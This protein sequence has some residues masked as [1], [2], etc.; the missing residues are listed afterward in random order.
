MSSFLG[1]VIDKNYD[2]IVFV[3]KY[4]NFDKTRVANSVDVIKIL[5]MFIKKRLN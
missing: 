5:T 1:G 3:S 4:L 2:D